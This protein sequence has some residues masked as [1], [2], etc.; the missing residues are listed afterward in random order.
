MGD[1]LW[2]VCPHSPYRQGTTFYTFEPPPLRNKCRSMWEWCIKKRKKKEKKP[3]TK[4]QHQPSKQIT[5]THWSPQ[6]SQ[7][8]D[9]WSPEAFS[10]LEYVLPWE[11]LHSQG[12]LV[13]PLKGYWHSLIFGNNGRGKSKLNLERGKQ[14]RPMS[15]L[16]AP[17]HW[18]L[19][20]LSDEWH[21]SW[22]AWGYAHMGV[23]CP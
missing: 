10:L 18:E 5:S 1:E 11:G 12:R 16:C 17:S 8:Q 9:K 3:T 20:E 19:W 23:P 21:Q 2:V 13:G 22:Q 4:K 14:C 6:H 15:F 7:C